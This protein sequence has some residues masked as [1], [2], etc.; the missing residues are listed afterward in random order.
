M[1][2]IIKYTN[3][4][5]DRYSGKKAYD[6]PFSKRTLDPDVIADLAFREAQ[7]HTISMGVS[8]SYNSSTN[9]GKIYVG[10]GRLAGTF[11]V[12]NWADLVFNPVEK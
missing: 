5:I 6:V 4:G 7:G 3:V 1:K 12:V 8:A 11:I 9:I 10:M 2:V